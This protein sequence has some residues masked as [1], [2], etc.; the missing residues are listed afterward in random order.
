MQYETTVQGERFKFVS[1]NGYLCREVFGGKVHS[2][3][4][5]G[6]L[7]CGSA[8]KIVDGNIKELAD[9]WVSQVMAIRNSC[10]KKKRK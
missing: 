10:T 6:H 5:G 8:L 9:N 4:H 3:C 7:Q 2:C 1:V